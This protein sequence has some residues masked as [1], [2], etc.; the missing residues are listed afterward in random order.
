MHHIPKSPN[1]TPARKKDRPNSQ[2]NLVKTDEMSLPMR[3]RSENDPTITPSVRNLP[4]NR[5]Y[6]SRP[7]RAF[8][9]EKYNTL[10]PGYHFQI[11]PNRAP[12]RKVTRTLHQILRVP[13]SIIHH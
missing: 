13:E 7:P 6:L 4:R 12:P 10:R 5:G 3:G 8:C 2:Q 9:I 1:I 11:S